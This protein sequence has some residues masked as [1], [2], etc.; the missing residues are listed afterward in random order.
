MYAT[1][2]SPSSALAAIALRIGASASHAGRGPP[3][4][5]AGPCRAPSSP[6][7]TPAPDEMKS[8]CREL[9]RAAV[10]VDE[11]RIAAVD[12]DVAGLEVRLEV[13]D[14]AVDRLPG[15]DHREDPPRPFEHLHQLRRRVGGG[16]GLALGRAV[17]EG[18]R[19]GGIE[20]VADDRKAAALDVAREVGAHHAEPDHSHC[21]LHGVTSAASGGFPTRKS[22]S[23]ARGTL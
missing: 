7:E 20:V 14:D 22:I 21:V 5:I 11:E 17:E 4:M 6:P 19:L 9:V 12:Q 15:R 1:H 2:G 3:G 8:A 16:D 18:L 23:P 13:R 10:G